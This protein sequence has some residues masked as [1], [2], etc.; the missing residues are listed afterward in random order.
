VLEQQKAQATDGLSAVDH[1]YK[2]PGS[3]RPANAATRKRCVCCL[4]A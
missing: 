2:V 4:F 1:T 3:Q